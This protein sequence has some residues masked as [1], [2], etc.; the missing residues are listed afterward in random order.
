[1]ADTSNDFSGSGDTADRWNFFGNPSDFHSGASSIPTC[2]GFGVTKTGGVDT[3]G[4][5][6]TVQSGVSGIISK[7]P[8]SL[9]AQ[10]VAV[11][12]D[13]TTLRDGG[14]FVKG[15]S[16]MVPPKAGTFGTMGRNIFRD[17]GFKNVDFSIFKTFTYKERYSASFRAEFFNLLNHPTVANPYGGASG[18][19]GG[20]DPSAF[21]TFG[22]GCQTP[23]VG[24]GNPLVGSGSARAMQLG[25]KFTF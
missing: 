10:C 13:P 23:D 25:L 4:V 18:F 14:C 16:V 19:G 15:N 2:Q 22:C 12:P 3:S 24:A 6:C 17:Q 11:A 7:L 20:T 8:S 9:A 21:T 5:T 1:V